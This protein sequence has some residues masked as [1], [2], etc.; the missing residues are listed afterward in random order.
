MKR[1]AIAAAVLASATPAAAQEIHDCI[2]EPFMVVEIGAPVEGV[3][4]TVEAERGMVVRKGDV[5]ATLEASVERE[6]LRLAEQQAGSTIAIEI[7]KARAD[8]ALKQAERARQLVARNAGT[9]ADLDIAE[10]QLKTSLLE[11]AGAEEAHVLDQLERDRAEALLERR[12]VRSPIDGILLRRLIGPGEYV[13]SQTQVAQIADVDP[14]Y[15][16]VFLPTRLYSAVKVGESAIVAPGEPIG[17]SYRAEIKAIDQV[18]DA[19]SDTFGMRLQL[20]NPDRALP[21]GV[22]C[23]LRLDQSG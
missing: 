16:D 17:G 20:P 10:A 2:I 19:A 1:L 4:E 9:Q 21:A 6:T 7:A 18:F 3:I 13:D 23:S 5:I 14:L 22:D 11:V 12:V 15:V 8:L